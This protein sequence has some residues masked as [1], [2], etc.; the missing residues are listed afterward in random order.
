MKL[1]QQHAQYISRKI[2]IDL[3]HSSFVEIRKDK[4]SVTFEIKRIITE[5]IENEQMLDEKV[6]ELLNNQEESIEFYHAD[7]RQ[8][9][10]MTKKRLANDFGVIINLEDRLSDISHKLMDY[11]YEED[12][13]HFEVSDN[14]VKNLIYNAIDIFMKGF[15][16]ADTL[17]YEK[18]K[19]Y[20]RKLIPGTEDYDIIFNRLYEEEL[21]KKGLI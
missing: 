3:I 17:A 9:F 7:Y 13:I 2:M 6:T 11:L 20:K 8:L 19:T 18:I 5:D 15:D 10:W 14:Q 21:I 12:F 4:A 1:K 16:E